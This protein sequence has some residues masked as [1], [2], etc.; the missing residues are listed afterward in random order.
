MPSNKSDVTAEQLAEVRAER[1][2]QKMSLKDMARGMGVTSL[3]SLSTAM[4][5]QRGVSLE[6]LN[7]MR[8]ALGMAPVPAGKPLVEVLAGISAERL[9]EVLAG[10]PLVEV[11]EDGPA[12]RPGPSGAPYE[13]IHAHVDA[14][15]DLTLTYKLVGNPREGSM[16]HD[17]NV[18]TWKDRE[19]IDLVRQLL[20][21]DMDDPVE[22]VVDNEY[23]PDDEPSEDD[24]P[25]DPDDGGDP[26]DDES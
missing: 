2:R 12:G 26:D 20:S 16:S 7:K 21:V 19:I 4:S 17:E 3:S 5:G 1:K 15:G 22:I 13:R 14:D 25:S 24:R 8:A 6:Y 10:K 9:D 11:L 23:D 18:G